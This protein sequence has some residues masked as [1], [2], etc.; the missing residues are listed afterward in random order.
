M[1]DAMMVRSEAVLHTPQDSLGPA[2]E[3]D[4]A[5]NRADVRL[6]SVRAEI[7]QRRDLGIALALGDEGQD[8]LSRSEAPETAWC[9]AC[10]G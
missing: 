6:H 7:C 4:L 8:G 3:S 10:A 2:A 5:V 1:F 9:I